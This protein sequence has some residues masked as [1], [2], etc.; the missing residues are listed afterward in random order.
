[1]D[2]DVKPADGC[3]VICPYREACTHPG[4]WA[5]CWASCPTAALAEGLGIYDE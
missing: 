5:G 4:G 2:V 3:Q 1:M